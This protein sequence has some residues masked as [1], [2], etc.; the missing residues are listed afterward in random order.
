MCIIAAKPAGVAMPSEETI[1]QMWS[2]NRDGAGFMYA[3]KG[4]VHIEKG[5]MHYEDFHDAIEKLSKSNDMTKLPLVMHFRIATHGGVNP[6]N[7]HPFP[8][9]DSVGVL[10]KL[11]SS[12]T[13]GVAHNGII[14]ITPRK[15]ISDTMEYIISQLAPLYAGVKD[16]YRNEHLMRMISN[17]TGSRLAFLT[18]EGDIYTVGDFI[19]DKG[20]MY[21]NGSY[22]PFSSRYPSLVSCHWGDFND[23]SGL[24]GPKDYSDWFPLEDSYTDEGVFSQREVAWLDQDFGYI[25]GEEMDPEGMYAVDY[26]GHVFIYDYYVDCLRY[27]PGVT[28]WSCTQKIL[29]SGDLDPSMRMEEMVFFPDVTE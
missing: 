1:F 17:A 19:E 18:S 24:T 13:L 6:A 21:S 20:I 7:T 22:K 2:S 12:C 28:A 10:S 3:K 14:D 8:I 23:Y 15:G 25:T 26:L 27:L 5:F 4:K 29:K 11:K 9:T 16:F